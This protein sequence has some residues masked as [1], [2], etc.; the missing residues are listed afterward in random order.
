MKR[1]SGGSNSSGS[2]SANTAIGGGG[3][4]GSENRNSGASSATS[5][6]FKIY[7][8]KIE[9]IKH[10]SAGK[11]MSTS[12]TN[13]EAAGISGADRSSMRVSTHLVMKVKLL[14][15]LSTLNQQ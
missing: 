1:L 3:G 2:S 9:P 10:A 7:N 8:D 12:T 4:G 14:V 6:R 11:H 15:M 13:A 5:L